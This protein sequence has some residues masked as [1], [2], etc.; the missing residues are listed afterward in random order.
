MY[1]V[2]K[3]SFC[4]YTRPRALFMINFSRLHL[5]QPINIQVL[6]EI[7]IEIHIILSI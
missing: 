2:L 4:I 6:V 7:L 1:G 3:E 5:L